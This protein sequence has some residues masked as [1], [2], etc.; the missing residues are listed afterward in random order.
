MDFI[1][2]ASAKY[3]HVIPINDKRYVIDAKMGFIASR[4]NKAFA[5]RYVNKVFT[6]TIQTI[7]MNF[8]SDFVARSLRKMEIH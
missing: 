1:Q 5:Y 4:F 2:L 6:G 7:L 3:R 8:D